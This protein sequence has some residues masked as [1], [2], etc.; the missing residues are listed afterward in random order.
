MHKLNRYFSAI[1]IV[2]LLGL[3]ALPVT[4]QDAAKSAPI[5]T[6]AVEQGAEVG[7]R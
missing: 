3:C 5:Q 7:Q 1:L 6:R 4:P 2:V